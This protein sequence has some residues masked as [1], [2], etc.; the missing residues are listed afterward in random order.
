[1]IS[2]EGIDYALE[3]LRYSAEINSEVTITEKRLS[4]LIDLLDVPKDKDEDFKK[5]D[6]EEVSDMAFETITKSRSILLESGRGDLGKMF[7]SELLEK[8][9]EKYKNEKR[10]TQKANLEKVISYFMEF[11]PLL[12]LA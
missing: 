7:T 11:S 12:F 3:S 6:L 8:T 1:M 2:K 9:L 4:K 10:K 5:E